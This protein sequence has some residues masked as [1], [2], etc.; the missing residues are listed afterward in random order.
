MQCF[1]VAFSWVNQF[2][3]HYLNLNFLVKPR[4]YWDECVY[5]VIFKTLLSCFAAWILLPTS[6]EI[7]LNT[8]RASV[9]YI[10][11]W[12]YC[13]AAGMVLHV[14]LEQARCCLERLYWEN[15]AC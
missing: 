4:K 3:N 14:T 11:T 5:L 1:C 10:R 6:F 2:Q 15:H 13:Y 7:D 12:L 9:R 8:L